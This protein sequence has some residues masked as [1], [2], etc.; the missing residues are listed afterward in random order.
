MLVGVRDMQKARS[1]SFISVPLTQETTASHSKVIIS[2]F[3]FS[4]FCLFVVVVVFVI[5]AI[6]LGLSRGI[7]RFPG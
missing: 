5:V 1:E 3:F 7:W 4:V 6:S 2:F